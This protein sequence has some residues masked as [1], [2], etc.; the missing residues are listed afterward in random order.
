MEWFDS[1][2]SLLKVYWLI[3]GVA[4]LIFII[5]MILTFVGMDASDGL[6]ADFD[7]DFDADGPFQFFSLRNLVNFLL[8][9]GWGGVCFYNSFESKIVVGVLA[10]LVGALF[11]LFF[12]FLMKQL[13]KLGKDNTFR[14]DSTVDKYADVYLAIPAEKSGKGKIQI[15]VNGAYHEIDAMTEGEKIP[16]GAKAKVVKIIDSQTVLVIKL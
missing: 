2:D 13:M 1:L 3:A 14:I 7:G 12:F 8:G 5:Q 10:I 11:V 9:F 15:S 4:S 6:S 16:T